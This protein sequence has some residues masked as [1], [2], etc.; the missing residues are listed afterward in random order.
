V[1][2]SQRNYIDVLARLQEQIVGYFTLETFDACYSRI[3]A[4][5]TVRAKCMNHL[6]EV[7]HRARHTEM[8]IRFAFF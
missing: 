5:Y 4:S 3:K 6:P 2:I 1:Q 8:G 7:P